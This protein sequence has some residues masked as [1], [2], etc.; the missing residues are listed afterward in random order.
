MTS[1]ILLTADKYQL[2]TSLTNNTLGFFARLWVYSSGTFLY[3]TILQYLVY[4]KLDNF[5]VAMQ[6]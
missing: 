4:N 5:I 3:N 6:I 1:N 2:V